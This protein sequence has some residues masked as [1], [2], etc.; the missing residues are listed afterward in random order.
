MSVFVNHT[1]GDFLT[2]SDGQ[3]DA[4][5]IDGKYLKA[6]EGRFH[7]RGNEFTPTATASFASHFSLGN[8]ELPNIKKCGVQLLYTEEA[9]RFGCVRGA[10]FESNGGD[11]IIPNQITKKMSVCIKR[12]RCHLFCI[13]SRTSNCIL[14]KILS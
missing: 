8:K 3:F 9:E 11:S 5:G 14:S 7:A 12:R 6:E 10:E 2:S 13:K 1:Y 4:N